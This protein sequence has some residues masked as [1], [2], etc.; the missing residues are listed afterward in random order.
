MNTMNK[1]K[2]GGH[3]TPQSGNKSGSSGED[4]QGQRSQK[5]PQNEQAGRAD[6]KQGDTKDQ[7]TKR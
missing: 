7:Q 5:A 3:N 1:N 6:N 2:A 4:K